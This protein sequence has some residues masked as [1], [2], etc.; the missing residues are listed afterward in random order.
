MLVQPHVV[1]LLLP[2][3]AFGVILGAGLWGAT[4]LA[5]DS[6]RIPNKQAGLGCAVG[7]HILLALAATGVTSA[8]FI[9]RRRH[10]DL[11]GALLPRQVLETLDNNQATSFGRKPADTPAYLLLNMMGDLLEGKAPRAQDV[12]FIRTALMSNMDVYQPFNLRAT[13][14]DAN[15][16]ADVAQSLMNQLGGF[17]VDCAT[18]VHLSGNANS[19][20][21]TLTRAGA[22]GAAETSEFVPVPVEASV[23]PSNSEQPCESLTSALALLLTPQPAIWQDVSTVQD[24]L[25][26][27]LTTGPIDARELK[28]PV[29]PTVAAAAAAL[30][31]D[32]RTPNNCIQGQPPPTGNFLEKAASLI[33]RNRR[34]RHMGGGDVQGPPTAVVDLARDAVSRSSLFG[35]GSNIL[36]RRGSTAGNANGNSNANGVRLNFRRA[37]FL[38]PSA[39]TDEHISATVNPTAN[40]SVGGGPDDDSVTCTTLDGESCG[41]G[42]ALALP[43]GEALVPRRLSAV[44]GMLSK[45]GTGNLTSSRKVSLDGNPNILCS[46]GGRASPAQSPASFC[47][48]RA[49]ST[50][51]PLIHVA[52]ELLQQAHSRLGLGGAGGGGGVFRTT[53]VRAMVD[54]NSTTVNSTTNYP[55]TAA[56]VIKRSMP[57]PLSV[58]DEVER[59]LAGA[60]RWQFNT[61]A[62]QEATQGHALSALGFYLIQKAGLLK[63]F[64]IKPVTLARVLRQI[65]AGYLDN[66]YHNAVHAADVLQTLHVVIHAT[67]LHVHYLDRLGLFAAYY[68]AIVHD[69]G[70]PGMTNDFLVAISDPLAVRYNDRSPLENHHCAAS[71]G[72]LQRPELDFLAPL[73]QSERSNFRKQVIEMV[74]ATDMKQHFSIL[75]HFNTVH[76]LAAY[77]QAAP[78]APSP[79][80][81]GRRMLRRTVSH[82]LS[83][84]DTTP[85]PTS[86]VFGVY[87]NDPPPKP[88]DETERLLS[89]QMALKAADIGHLG[90]ELE[91]HK[92]WLG[93]LEEEFFRQGDRERELGHSISPLFD[94]AKQGVSK[95]QVGFYDFVALPLVHAL[96]S[97]FPGAHQLMNDFVRNYNHWRQV[98]GQ[99]PVLIPS[100][101]VGVT[102]RCS[103]R[104]VSSA[105][106]G[107]SAGMPVAASIPRNSEQGGLSNLL[108]TVPDDALESRDND[109]HV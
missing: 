42:V 56:A 70:H 45:R 37:S 54:V 21:R 59:L 26:S 15:L 27:D 6:S 100:G 96:S 30:V 108:L 25:A 76:R 36:G 98:D 51:S 99:L 73:S 3:L 60:D 69:Y 1:T 106:T 92:R 75:S 41:G 80:K 62:L 14:K 4:Q 74:L 109:A 84:N 61:W 11:L 38:I 2:I 49:S 107:V 93:V 95:S 31:L 87:W 12:L 85:D 67:Q 34:R 65:E 9:S 47:V 64:H 71:F 83:N 53:S 79:Y 105:G 33:D 101:K 17:S 22:G 43:T 89:L 77:S 52:S 102:G 35:V 103:G 46:S 18:T 68:A 82:A 40:S 19:P 72:L 20:F 32:R 78:A 55:A 104:A 5:T 63:A 97:A 10:R 90:E 39:T 91:V 7:A 48:R 23:S 50:Q 57:P 94:R 44:W 16:D 81:H 29:L 88:V 86:A 13:I 66:P 24:D 58:I 8:L 28:P